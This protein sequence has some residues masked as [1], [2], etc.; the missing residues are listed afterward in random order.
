MQFRGMSAVRGALQLEADHSVLLQIKLNMGV[1]N[2]SAVVVNWVNT[3][4]G[5]QGSPSPA[6]NVG[7]VVRNLIF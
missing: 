7:V 6:N 3:G 5:D 4:F 1:G 2:I